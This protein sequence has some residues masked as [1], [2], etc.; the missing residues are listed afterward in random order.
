MM[1][2]IDGKALVYNRPVPVHGVL[3]AAG[4]ERHPALID[5]V[6]AEIGKLA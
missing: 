3:V 6:R 5:I 4:R 1:T 2:A